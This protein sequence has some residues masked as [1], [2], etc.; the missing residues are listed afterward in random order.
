MKLTKTLVT[1]IFFQLVIKTNA[2][3]ILP[4]IDSYD[5][6]SIGLGY[7]PDFSGAGISIL[8]YAS[9]KHIGIFGGVGV[10]AAGVAMDGGVKL[11]LL[12]LE[13]KAK[14]NPFLLGMY[15][16]NGAVSVANNSSYNK[17][18]YGTTVG[19]GLDL[20]FRPNSRGYWTWAWMFTS[21][22]LKEMEYMRYLE[23]DKQVVFP[24]RPNAFRF[25]I[26]YRYRL[27]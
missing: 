3:V 2:Q 22:N 6:T 25:S 26:G 19:I 16:Y 18:F 8:R 10:T 15:G 17:I 27:N 11:R 12:L 5:R 1:I 20:K 24:T 9:N 21:T 4:K 7:G 13:Y 23:N 14:I